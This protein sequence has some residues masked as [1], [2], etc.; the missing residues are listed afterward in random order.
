VA[1]AG[2][3][4]FALV[5]S[6]QSKVA[7][8]NLQKAVL[9]TA[10]IKKASAALEAKYKPRQTEMEKL[11][12]ELDEIQQRLQSLA[13][14]LTQQAEAEMNMQGQ[15]K[16]RDLQRLGEDLQ[17]DVD[18]E[19]SD[20]LTKSTQRMQE[21]VRKIAEEKGVDVVVNVTNTVF[22]KP[23]LEIT[24]EATAAYDKVHPAK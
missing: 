1:A 18:A 5:V 22:F 11:R 23:A 10:E 19:R 2:L 3:V 24:L 8:I 4:L 9:D 13:G 15:R 12:K 14:K 16:Q 21:V 6:A 20:I 7:V 17:A